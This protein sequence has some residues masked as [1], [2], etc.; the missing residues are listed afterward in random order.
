MP[1]S[2]SKGHLEKHKAAV[3]EAGAE[4]HCWRN[5]NNQGA[6]TRHLQDLGIVRDMCLNERA[7]LPPGLQECKCSC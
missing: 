4:C 2:G 3:L 6:L 1:I 5:I 7:E